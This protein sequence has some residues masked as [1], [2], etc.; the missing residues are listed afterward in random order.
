[1]SDYG[2]HMA[3]DRKHF[4]YCPD[5]P[6]GVYLDVVAE[7]STNTCTQRCA[8][9]DRSVT[10]DVPGTAFTVVSSDTSMAW[11]GN[12]AAARFHLPDT[13]AGDVVNVTCDIGD[14]GQ[15]ACEEKRRGGYYEHTGGDG[16]TSGTCTVKY[17]R[18]DLGA[19][20]DP[21][22][23][24]GN[25]YYESVFADNVTTTADIVGSVGAEHNWKS[26]I[27]GTTYLDLTNSAFTWSGKL[28]AQPTTISCRVMV[29]NQC[30][31]TSGWEYAI[32]FITIFPRMRRENWTTEVQLAGV[33]TDWLAGVPRGF[34]QI[35][36][37]KDSA[38]VEPAYGRNAN[39]REPY[40]KNFNAVVVPIYNDVEKYETDYNGFESKVTKI[41]SGPNTG[42]YYN[43]DATM[44]EIKRRILSNYWIK[45]TAGHPI[46]PTLD[47]HDNPYTNWL[48]VFES[49]RGTD[50]KCLN[51]ST[52]GGTGAGTF[53]QANLYHEGLGNPHSPSNR[54]LGH[55][56]RLEDGFA[57]GLRSVLDPIYR[58]DLQY[59]TSIDGLRTKNEIERK[60]ASDELLLLIGAL[61]GFV[62]SDSLKH[63]YKGDI[64]I[65]T[66]TS[67]WHI[68]GKETF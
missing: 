54:L 10:W 67:G 14:A 46:L 33:N 34:P 63:S 68:V 30:D 59:S 36:W 50:C 40:D 8:H 42:L 47:N 38:G 28:V 18:L 37:T 25:S 3:E 64:I 2:S 12:F 62:K 44:Y 61:H 58:C 51:P 48:S 9:T 23:T 22:P 60:E 29:L 52:H 45:P 13:V 1:M 6:G 41:T 57:N 17:W 56:S 65:Y 11:N 49:E 53:Y 16:G 55:H 20:A 43:N 31:P 26:W 19:D 35:D 27:D 4:V 21:H 5:E 7:F 66:P 39:A 24:L 15:L 32:E